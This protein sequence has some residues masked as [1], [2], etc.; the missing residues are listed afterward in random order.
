MVGIITQLT[1]VAIRGN[2]NADTHW[3]ISFID[4]VSHY[5][6]V[7]FMVSKGEASNK[8]K[9]YLTYLE[10]QLEHRTKIV[11]VDNGKEYINN[12]LLAWCRETGI[13]LHVS[14]LSTLSPSL[15]LFSCPCS[16][17]LS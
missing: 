3:Y 4:D 14:D 10:C 9:E 15:G 5:C 8:L 13:D 16:I 6:E 2:P 12:K 17:F 7:R 11:Q 1:S